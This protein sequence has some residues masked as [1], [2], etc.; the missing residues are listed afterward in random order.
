MEDNKVRP[1]I[2]YCPVCNDVRKYNIVEY[3]FQIQQSIE[4]RYAC[5]VCGFVSRI[6][7]IREK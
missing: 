2:R 6:D 3:Y 7:V 5:Y 4:R 1:G